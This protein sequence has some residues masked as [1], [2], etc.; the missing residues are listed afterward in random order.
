MRNVC[1]ERGAR[2]LA[3]LLVAWLA[4]PAE[5]LLAES[6]DDPLYLYCTDAGPE[7]RDVMVYLGPDFIVPGQRPR[8][9]WVQPMLDPADIGPGRLAEEMRRGETFDEQ[10]RVR[11]DRYEYYP[12]YIHHPTRFQLLLFYTVF[13]SQQDILDF[14]NTATA[15]K[16]SMVID[17]RTGRVSHYA[18]TYDLTCE[19]R[20]EADFRAGYRMWLSDVT[21]EY[22]R[23]A[24]QRLF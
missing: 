22:E 4:L 24:A 7:A 23:R 13:K 17:R 11:E 6:F 5:R 1:S 21:S 18:S 2:W 16:A 10:T 12:Q 19:P 15:E 20:S 14:A 9:A 3:V 8:N